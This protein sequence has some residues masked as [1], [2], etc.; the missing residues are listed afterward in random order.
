MIFVETTIYQY[1]PT[2]K[3]FEKLKDFEF[4][5]DKLAYVTMS[6]NRQYFLV[7]YNP[8][9]QVELY[10]VKEDFSFELVPLMEEFNI[11]SQ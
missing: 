11:S 7:E 9:Q 10:E 2:T 3:I 1:N 5:S 6:G 4:K 8:W